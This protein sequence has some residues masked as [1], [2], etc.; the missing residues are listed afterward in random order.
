MEI[1]DAIHK[2]SEIFGAPGALAIVAWIWERK[3]N[4]QLQGRLMR[5]ASA[6]LQAAGETK[7]ALETLKEVLR[8]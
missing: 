3:N 6:Q 8:K 5:L 1:L 4:K 2:L 7:A